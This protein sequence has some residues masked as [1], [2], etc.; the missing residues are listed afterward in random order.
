MG[1]YKEQERQMQMELEAKYNRLAEQRLLDEE[2]KIR[3][4]CVSFA[5]PCVRCLTCGPSVG[6]RSS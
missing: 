6:I 3:L 1:R 4:E 2:A 5:L